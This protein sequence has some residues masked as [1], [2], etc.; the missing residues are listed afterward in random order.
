[1]KMT[2]RDLRQILHEMKLT[3]DRLDHDASVEDMMDQVSRDYNNSEYKC[4]VEWCDNDLASDMCDEH[5][6]EYKHG[7]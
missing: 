5:I 7:Y 6:N 4:I 2:S 1:M 3:Q